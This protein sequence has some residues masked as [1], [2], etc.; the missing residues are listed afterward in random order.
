[1][2]REQK[3]FLKSFLVELV[4][5]AAFV[6]GYFFLVLHFL[7][8]WL[9]ELFHGDTRIYAIVALALMIGQGIVLE[10]VTTA[11]LRFIRNRSD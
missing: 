3:Q 11:L 1:M 7:A 4:V 5:Y 9:A 6:L 2:N 10:S 8:G